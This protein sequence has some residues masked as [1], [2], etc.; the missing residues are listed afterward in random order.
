[1]AGEYFREGFKPIKRARRLESC[2]LAACHGR[3]MFGG[4]WDADR[5]VFMWGRFLKILEVLIHR[6]FGF[7]AGFD[8][9]FDSRGFGSGG[10]ELGGQGFGN[11]CPSILL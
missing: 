7:C 5:V 3:S 8:S 2:R 10:W 11:G 6:D 4:E 1:M 9:F